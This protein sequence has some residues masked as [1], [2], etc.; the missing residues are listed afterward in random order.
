MQV[1]DSH[2]IT[3]K[4]KRWVKLSHWII[5]ISFFLLAFSGFVILMCHPRLY[6]GEVGNDLTPAL[7][8][9]PVSRNYQHGGWEKT[10][11]FFETKNSPVSSSR[12]YD[13][14]NENGWGRSL[15]FLSAWF[16]IVTGVGYLLWG[17]LTG[18]FRRNLF[19]RSKEITF[20]S[21]GTDIKNHLRFIVKPASGGPTYGLLQKSSYLV[22]VFFPAAA[23][24]FNRTY[25]VAR[26]NSIISLP[27]ENIFRCP[28]GPHHS[29]FCFSCPGALFDHSRGHDHYVRI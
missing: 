27:V 5:T 12:T 21:F 6:W 11:A 18:H 4:H 23:G 3:V 8:E 2:Q 10:T 29:L 25:H 26:D 1:T 9:L 19:P 24:S 16:L 14:W 28:V 7:F 20:T 13:I 15:H 17:A 22:V